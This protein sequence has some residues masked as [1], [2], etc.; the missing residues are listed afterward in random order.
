MLGFLDDEEFTK[1]NTDSEL[2]MWDDIGYSLLE[3]LVLN[4]SALASRN[5]A[6]EKQR[7]V[8]LKT[9]EI[10]RKVLLVKPSTQMDCYTCLVNMSNDS[11]IEEMPEIQDF[12]DLLGERMVSYSEI[13][14]SGELKRQTRE[15]FENGKQVKAE[16]TNFTESN[17][18]TSS[19]FLLFTGFYKL[20][21][22]SSMKTRIYF[23]LN[24]KELFK[25]FLE[26]GNEWEVKYTLQVLAQLT[27]D[28][29]IATDLGKDEFYTKYIADT[30]GKQSD[31]EAVNAKEFNACKQ[32]EWN[33]NSTKSSAEESSER[34]R[35][36]IMISYN[37]GS[38][39]MCLK[40]K[41]GL[42]SSGYKVWIFF[43]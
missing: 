19:I 25:I 26:K 1:K 21:I 16:F 33:I 9:A 30:I 4:L 31:V 8:E 14:V 6:D 13:F 11:Q 2:K 17:N 37:T 7:Y 43:K 34:S 24:A 38:R 3:Y 12:A 23:N 20:S 35:A 29:E 15:I 32:I 5:S 18:T 40:M 36:D 41:S 22:N 10:M 27:F 42:E 28:P 39:D